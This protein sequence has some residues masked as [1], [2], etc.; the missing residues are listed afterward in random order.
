MKKQIRVLGIDDAP[1]RFGDG[2]TIVIGVVMRIPSYM[3]AVMSTKVEVDGHDANTALAEMINSSN[4]KKQLKLV[5]LD[6]VALGGFNVVDI[7]TLFERTGIPV[8][9]ITRDRPDFTGME[10]AL[11]EHFDD[12]FERL[13]VIKKGDLVELETAHKPI[14]MK[15]V[16]IGFEDIEDIIRQATVRGA[17]PEVIRVAHLIATGVV[18]GESYGRA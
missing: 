15:Y 14:F 16:G 3:E 12:W 7:H 6:G 5:M 4:Y 9:T 10:Y 1:F 18:K 11:R 17:I 8:V 13:E 2:R